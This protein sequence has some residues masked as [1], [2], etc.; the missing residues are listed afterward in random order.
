[1]SAG[2]CNSADILIRNGD[3]RSVSLNMGPRFEDRVIIPT[4]DYGGH[5]VVEEDQDEGR[6][7]S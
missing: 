2:H 5:V 1:M 7:G 3:Q 6:T 4:C